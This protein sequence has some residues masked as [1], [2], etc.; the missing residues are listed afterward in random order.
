LNLD[1]KIAAGGKNISEGQ[2]QIV[3]LVRALLT[4]SYSSDSNDYT[5][6]IVLDEITSNLDTDSARKVIAIIKKELSASL[7]VLL[8]SHRQ[9]DLEQCDS[10][11]VLSDGE[12]IA[13]GAELRGIN[14]HLTLD[15]YLKN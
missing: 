7:S 4:N 1:L 5:K 11:I 15:K 3:N 14:L 13:K 2:K 12:I 10:L 6:I 9:S 8:I